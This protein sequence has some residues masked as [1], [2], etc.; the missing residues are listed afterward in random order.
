MTPLALNQIL[1]LFTWFPLAALLFFF[2]LIARFYEKFSG[3]RTG[4][5]FYI[6]P[7][8]FFGGAAVRYASLNHIGGDWLGDILSGLAGITLIGLCLLLYHRMMVG[9]DAPE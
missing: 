8:M 2:L 1:L 6:L 7:I 3:E 5:Y 9:R 4:F